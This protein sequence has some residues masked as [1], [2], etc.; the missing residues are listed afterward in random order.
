MQTAAAFKLSTS[1]NSMFA[2]ENVGDLLISVSSNHQILIGGDANDHSNVAAVSITSNATN[3]RGLL[4]SG[5]INT[6]VM[7][8]QGINLSFNTD[9]L[10]GGGYELLGGGTTGGFSGGGGGVI[11]DASNITTSNLT[12]Y[13]RGA[14]AEL[15]SSNI[16]T[17][18]LSVGVL[19]G[20]GKDDAWDTSFIQPAASAIGTAY[21]SL[22]LFPEKDIVVDA[23]SRV[24]EWGEYTVPAQDVAAAPAF[25]ARTGYLNGPFVRPT[26]NAQLGYVGQVQTDFLGSGGGVTFT[27][28]V[29][30]TEPNTAGKTA[31]VFAGLLS[32][33]LS[34]SLSTNLAY[35]AMS[36]GQSAAFDFHDVAT[37]DHWFS[38]DQWHFLAITFDAVANTF[39]VYKDGR[40]IQ[41]GPCD[42]ANRGL[43]PFSA[44]YLP[45]TTIDAASIGG[46]A[47]QRGDDGV[48]VTTLPGAS[49]AAQLDAN[50]DIASVV[51]FEGALTQ[52]QVLSLAEAHLRNTKLV[53]GV[54]MRIEGSTVALAG[55]ESIAL[56][57]KSVELNNKALVI[58]PTTI[59]VREGASFGVGCFPAF[60]LDIGVDM[61]VRGRTINN[62]R[63]LFSTPLSANSPTAPMSDI[64]LEASSTADSFGITYDPSTGFFTNGPDTALYTLTFLDYNIVDGA[65]F[66]SNGAAG[67][68]WNT[69]RTGEQIG[70]VALQLGITQTFLL[71][72]GQ[73]FRIVHMGATEMTYSHPTQVLITQ[74][75]VLGAMS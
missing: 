53:D 64:P 68:L 34:F 43:A 14:I 2:N 28:M 6:N 50:I 22:S 73:K 40:I 37:H 19:Q 48:A 26:L 9:S 13:V 5:A 63:C 69:R 62:R 61:N 11:A 36:V 51:V 59:E 44:W 52:A 17:S 54:S 10:L 70:P 49:Y 31:V 74:M 16:T 65:T 1:N 29:R 30:K 47:H 35:S 41:Q 27:T 38:D 58:R 23:N 67:V 66:N 60:P 12:V 39:V 25:F 20:R 75:H 24:V 71:W 33:G 8:T 72:S 15:A 45:G 18:N 56:D 57:A 7:Q 32:G 42:D 46:I 21:A 3:I 55:G 4:Q